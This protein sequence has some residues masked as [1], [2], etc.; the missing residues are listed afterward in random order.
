MKTLPGERYEGSQAFALMTLIML[1]M[2]LTPSARAIGVPFAAAYTSPQTATI[3]D[4]ATRS[5]AIAAEL[6]TLTTAPEWTEEQRAQFDA[7]N[8]EL[9]SL[10]ARKADIEKRSAVL[11]RAQGMS[12][13]EPGAYAAAVPGA[14][15]AP[16]IVRKQTADE[17]HDL[18]RIREETRTRSEYDQR[19]RENALRSIESAPSRK[20]EF[21]GLAEIVERSDVGEEGRGEIASRVLV[22]GSPTYRSAFNKYLN[23]Q[24]ALWTPEEARA[25]ALA[26]TGTTTTGGYAVPYVF[27]P[28]MMHIG[29]WTQQNPFRAACRT[30]NITNGNNWRTVTVGAITAAYAD[31]AAAS[32]EGGPTFGQPTYTVQT[33]KAFATLSVETMQDRPDISGELASIFGE[34]K[35]TLEEN[36]FAVGAGSTNLPFGM[37]TALAYTAVTTATNDVTAIADTQLVE[38]ALPLRFR[39]KAEWFMNRSTIRQLQA[40]DTG[41][42]YF[43]GAGIQY[44]GEQNPVRSDSGNT[45]LR[46]L[47][48]PV[49]EVPSAVS[50]LTTDA[51][52]IAALVDPSSYIIVDRIGMNVEVIPQM[53]DG[54]TPSFPTLQRGV[55][56]YW[57]N[58]AKPVN[59]DAGRTMKVQ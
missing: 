11:A 56:C 32:V 29:A 46:L 5:A 42:R 28:T 15:S 24:H 20:G 57:R 44:A 35:D 7:L 55:I 14:Y 33:A 31:E 12:T 2:G 43:S 3:D 54:A 19:V 8:T 13:T 34:A 23:G 41:Q 18:G 4:I 9:T 36:K 22:T 47:G 51:A 40:L 21:D 48:Y 16:A 58:T 59:A 52:I 38:A 37:F 6:E 49:W 50:T 53:L 25:A 45:G 1:G 26:V 10:E 30:V 17:L 39:A 27:D